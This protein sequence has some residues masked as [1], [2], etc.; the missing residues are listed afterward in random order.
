M[1]AGLSG[2]VSIVAVGDALGGLHR[3]VVPAAVALVELIMRL[4][5]QQL[6]AQ[7]ALRHRCAVGRDDHDIEGRVGAVGERAAGEHAA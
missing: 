7:P 5:A 6:V 4:D 1:R 2:V 3:L